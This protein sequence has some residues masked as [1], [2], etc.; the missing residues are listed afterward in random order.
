MLQ[1]VQMRREAEAKAAAEAQREA[2]AVAKAKADADARASAE[3][4]RL[5]NEAAKV[6][7]RNACVA[8]QNV[9]LF[10]RLRHHAKLVFSG[11]FSFCVVVLAASCTLITMLR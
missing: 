3:A 6:G 10:E 8:L 2:D 5:A 11:G 9:S 1:K 7:I 4:R